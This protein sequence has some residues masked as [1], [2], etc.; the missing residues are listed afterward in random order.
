MFFKAERESYD[1]K[2]L[3]FSSRNSKICNKKK[4]KKNNN[5]QKTHPVRVNFFQF[6]HYLIH[7]YIYTYTRNALHSGY[8]Y[9]KNNT[10]KWIFGKPR[11][12]IFSYYNT[13]T[14]THNYPCSWC[15]MYTDRR[16]ILY[17]YSV[18]MLW[19][20]YILDIYNDNLAH[21]IENDDH[22]VFSCI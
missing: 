19:I 4:K 21:M 7:V 15:G 10:T 13:H 14:H 17:F 11:I 8:F 1:W 5:T 12:N 20:F 22:N 9:H 3:C 18:S 16:K 6:Q 2:L